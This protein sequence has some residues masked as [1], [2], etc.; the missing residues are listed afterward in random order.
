MRSVVVW[1]L[2]NFKELNVIIKG[3]VDG[4]VEALSDSL[5]KLIYTKKLLVS[6]IHKG[7]GQITESDVL[8]A[9]ASDAIIIGFN[10]RPSL[11]ASKTCR[12]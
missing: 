5:Q 3:D 1:H 11:Q 9:T 4:S 7:V 8:L 6:V 2:D 10:V 12:K